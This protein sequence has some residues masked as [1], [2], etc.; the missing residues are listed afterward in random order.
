MKI[1]IEFDEAD[2]AKLA[3]EGG[4]WKYTVMQL[5][6]RLRYITKHNIYQNREASEDEHNMAHYIREQIREILNDNNLVI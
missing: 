2:D 1:T 6:Q 3:M 4:D 5:D